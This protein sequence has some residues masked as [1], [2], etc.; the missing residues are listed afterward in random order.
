[1][2]KKLAVF[3]WQQDKQQLLISVR[4]PDASNPFLSA[5]FSLSHISVPASSIVISPPFKT[6]LQAC[7]PESSKK[8]IL[9]TRVSAAGQLHALTKVSVQTDGAEVPSEKHLGVW[10][11]G[12]ALA[13]FQGTFARPKRLL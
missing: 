5:S 11:T 13:D 2:P 7:H 1:M 4:L 10:R 9:A 3:H 8:Q 12:I 6:I